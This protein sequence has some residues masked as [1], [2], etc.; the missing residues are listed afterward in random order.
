M[1]L[2][3]CELDGEWF[4]D[5]IDVYKHLQL[6]LSVRSMHRRFKKFNFVI[7]R[8]PNREYNS[9]TQEFDVLACANSNWMVP[10]AHLK[11][12]VEDALARIRKPKSVKI[13][14]AK[15]LGVEISADEPIECGAIE[16]LM[17]ACPFA[18]ETQYKV[19]RRKLD[20]FIP[21]LRLGVQV[22][23]N[24]HANYDDADEK[25]YEEEL[26][27]ANISLIRFVPGTP[28]DL[29][30]AVWRHTLTPEFRAFV[31]MNSLK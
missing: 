15:S 27:D 2:R 29:V 10:L 14:L 3:A 30:R 4:Y 21:R 17:N 1:P 9:Q 19:G 5:C 20:A 6:T 13:A 28:A 26:R 7:Q 8:T 23:E 25:S 12:F 22:D 16:M 24:N 11:E 18:M 31:A